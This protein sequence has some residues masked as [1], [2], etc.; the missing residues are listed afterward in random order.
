MLLSGSRVL[1]IGKNGTAY[2]LDAGNL[3]HVG[4][5]VATAGIGS[6]PFGTAA[7][8]GARVFVPCTG[9]L[10]AVDT[11][12]SGVTVAWRVSGGAGSPIVAA[13]HVWSLGHDGKLKAIDPASGS[14]VFTLQLASPVSRFVTPSA[15]NG[16]LFVADGQKITAVSLR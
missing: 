11:S 1:A 4:T 9:A 5:P 2:L 8:L 10:V 3:G 16:R 7:V 6:S 12:A 14:V 13:G 15:A